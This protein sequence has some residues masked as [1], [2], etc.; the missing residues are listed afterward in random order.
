MKTKRFLGILLTM[1]LLV[2]LMPATVSASDVSINEAY[3]PD[4]NFRTYVFDFDQDN[5]GSLSETELAAVTV[6]TCVSRS[7]EPVK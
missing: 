4:N 1:S 6:I 2:G 3:F 5:D 7:I